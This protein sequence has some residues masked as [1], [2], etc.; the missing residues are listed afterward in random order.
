MEEEEEKEAL[1]RFCRLMISRLRHKRQ[2]EQQQPDEATG[3]KTTAVG[4]GR[5]RG[6]VRTEAEGDT[7]RKLRPAHSTRQGGLKPSTDLLCRGLEV[8]AVPL[9]LISTLRLR[10]LRE[11]MERVR[12]RTCVTHFYHMSVINVRKKTH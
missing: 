11:E 4:R 6:R 3:E 2:Q 7:D 8:Q 5:G 10:R 1:A 12:S 9:Q